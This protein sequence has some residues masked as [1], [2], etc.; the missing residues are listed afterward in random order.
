MCFPDLSRVTVSSDLRNDLPSL[1][2]S[3]IVGHYIASPS[4]TELGGKVLDRVA[5]MLTAQVTV[6]ERAQKIQIQEQEIVRRERELDSKVRK[7]AEA[8][9]YRLEKI[10]EANKSVWL[11]FFKACACVRNSVIN[12]PISL[13]SS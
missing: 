3:P 6:V 12:N 5:V 2:Y 7:P 10:A 8:E 9:K 1:T 11:L 13:F 4:T